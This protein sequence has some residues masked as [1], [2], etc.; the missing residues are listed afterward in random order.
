MLKINEIGV[1]KQDCADGKGPSEPEP[2]NNSQS[3]HW[4]LVE[5]VSETKYPIRMAYMLAKS[6]K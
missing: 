3:T 1:K 6:N 5:T 2:Y 4:V